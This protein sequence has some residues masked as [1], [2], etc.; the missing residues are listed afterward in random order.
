M[1]EKPEVL[2][3]VKALKTKIIGKTIKNV[4][5]YWDNIIEYPSVSEFKEKIR[6]QKIIL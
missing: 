4:E 5:V 6:N 3:V 1:P 2:T